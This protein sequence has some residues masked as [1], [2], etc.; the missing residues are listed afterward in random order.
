[1][2]KKSTNL[3]IGYQQRYFKL[4]SNGTILAYYKKKPDLQD[5]PQAAIQLDSVDDIG[6]KDE[7]ENIISIVLGNREFLLRAKTLALAE[8]WLDILIPI[9]NDLREA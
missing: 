6:M 1:M 4:H 9:V 3:L 5:K 8:E 2:E 7:K